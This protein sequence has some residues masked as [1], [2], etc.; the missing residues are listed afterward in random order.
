MDARTAIYLATCIAMIKVFTLNIWAYA[1]PYTERMQ[2]I[3]DW[4]E[5]EKPDLLAFQEAGFREGADQIR[6]LLA[7]LDYHIFHQLDDDRGE[8]NEGT[9]IASRW[10]INK[11]TVCSLMLSPNSMGYPYAAIAV[12]IEAPEPIG[13]FLFVCSKPSWELNREYE[14]ELQALKVVKLI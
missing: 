14:R 12:R 13:G 10:P 1:E 5:E 11:K 4:V 8:Q 7:G 9:C 6:D 2:L 3:R